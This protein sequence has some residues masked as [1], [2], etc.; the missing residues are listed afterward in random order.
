M[1][2]NKER[3]GSSIMF[4]KKVTAAQEINNNSY[5][6]ENNILQSKFIHQDRPFSFGAELKTTNFKK[7]ESPRMMNDNIITTSQI[8]KSGFQQ[9]PESTQLNYH[10]SS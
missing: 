1:D 7:V 2:T 3:K 5:Y 6:D 4:S 9:Q 8:Y 10:K